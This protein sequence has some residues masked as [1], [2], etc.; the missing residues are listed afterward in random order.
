M[1][2]RRPPVAFNA[3]TAIR[4]QRE[5][6]FQLALFVC[7]MMVMLDARTS[8]VH[9]AV[10]DLDD[11]KEPLQDLKDALNTQHGD[12]NTYATNITG[13]YHGNWTKNAYSGKS[14]YMQRVL[15]QCDNHAHCFVTHKSAAVWVH[16][17]WQLLTLRL[18]RTAV[19]SQCKCSWSLLKD[20][21]ISAWLKGTSRSLVNPSP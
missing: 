7:L 20:S 14:K 21:A 19:N 9:L 1:L 10:P 2:F 4:Q 6:L 12:G 13:R 8:Q 16:L 15:F 3:D 11:P 5:R 17:R 18:H